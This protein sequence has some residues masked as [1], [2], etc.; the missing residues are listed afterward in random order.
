MSSDPR[1]TERTIDH[2]LN[3]AIWAWCKAVAYTMSWF[4]VEVM[5]MLWVYWYAHAWCHPTVARW[6][7]TVLCLAVVHCGV[8]LVRACRALDKM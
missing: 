1:T 8:R 7:A 2:E 3:S 4:G 6:L 5:A